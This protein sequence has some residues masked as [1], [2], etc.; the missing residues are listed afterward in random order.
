MFPELD[1]VLDALGP[2]VT[3]FGRYDGDEVL[4]LMRTV[5]W[6][7]VPSIWWE[8]SPVVIQEARQAGVPLLV[9]DIGGMAENVLP[10]VDGL[11]FRRGSPVDLA[12]AMRQAAMAETRA[13]LGA[14]VREVIGRVEFLAGLRQ[15][16]GLDAGEAPQPASRIMA[17]HDHDGDKS[18]IQHPE[19]A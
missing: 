9:S 2:S 11:H 4:E 13:R 12:R 5:G 15:A 6:V 19:T 8:N 14:S 18:A 7:V 10:G 17:F 3:L 16:Y 1:A